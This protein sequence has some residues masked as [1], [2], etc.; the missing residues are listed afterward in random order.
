VRLSFFFPFFV[1]P[2]VFFINWAYPDMMA[3]EKKNSGRVN[4][5]GRNEKRK[6]HVL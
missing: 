5:I 1:M 6:R 2:P 3:A 4:N